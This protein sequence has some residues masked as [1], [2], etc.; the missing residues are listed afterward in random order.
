VEI[1]VQDGLWAWADARLTNLIL[2]Q[3]LSNAWKFSSK[4]PNPR[5][6]F[7]SVGEGQQDTFFVRDNGAG[8]DMAYA[9]QL[10]LPFHRLHAAEQF[11]GTGIGLTIAKRIL[12]RH[13]GRIW[14]VAELDKGAT[15]YFNLPS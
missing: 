7:G 15:F 1:L 9:D 13:G 4:R 2:L 10:F 8:F 5:I 6:E 14:A 3:L 12:Q 11:Q